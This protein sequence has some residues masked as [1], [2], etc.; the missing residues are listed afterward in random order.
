MATDGRIITAKLQRPR[1]WSQFQRDRMAM[2][3]A[4]VLLLLIIAVAVG[5]LLYPIS[6]SDIDFAQSTAP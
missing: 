3:G 2:L 5:P 4:L 6:Y 1:A